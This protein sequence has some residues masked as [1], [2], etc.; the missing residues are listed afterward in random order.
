M[1]DYKAKN[2]IDNG[3]LDFIL[4]LCSP[5]QWHP[6]KLKK[7]NIPRLT[8]VEGVHPPMINPPYSFEDIISTA[9]I[10]DAQLS[11]NMNSLY[12]TYLTVEQQ[13][14]VKTL[15]NYSYPR[16]IKTKTLEKV[17]DRSISELAESKFAEKLPDDIE[18]GD[19]V[20]NEDAKD[21]RRWLIDTNQKRIFPDLATYYGRGYALGGLKTLN[22]TVLETIPDGEPVE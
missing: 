22:K 1:S 12:N 13:E 8:P 3:I 6:E 16:Y 20:T 11:N 4:D 10:E 14:S 18:N 7:E 2:Y 9:G 15:N 21:F 19:V 5:E 17:V